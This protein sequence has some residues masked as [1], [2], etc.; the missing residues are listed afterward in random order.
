M[1]G[2]LTPLPQGSQLGAQTGVGQIERAHQLLVNL[3]DEQHFP[4]GT[5]FTVGRRSFRVAAPGLIWDADPE[6]SCAEILCQALT[7]G[8]AGDMNTVVDKLAGA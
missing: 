3:E 5:V 1:L 4:D 6:T 7:G 8:K 2:Q